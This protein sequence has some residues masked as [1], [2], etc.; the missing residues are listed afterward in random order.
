MVSGS[1][2][3]NFSFIDPGSNKVADAESNWGLIPQRTTTGPGK[4]PDIS[5][6]P[7]MF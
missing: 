1:V 6:S 7:Q 3:H 2:S 4:Q 5:A